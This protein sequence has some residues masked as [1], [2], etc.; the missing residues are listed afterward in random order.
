[1]LAEMPEMFLL[2]LVWIVP[3]VALAC[4]SITIG[5]ILRRTQKKNLGF[6]LSI[7]GVVFLG[8]LL[9]AFTYGTTRLIEA[10]LGTVQ[11]QELLSVSMGSEDITM[12][13][14]WGFSI[15]FFIV[16]L[17]VIVAVIAIFLDIQAWFMQKKR[18]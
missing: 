1:M 18:L 8:I 3:F 4:V 14:S 2:L 17:A 11:G 9:A 6:I 15:G 7:I 5:I 16:C 10:S 12:Q 13:S